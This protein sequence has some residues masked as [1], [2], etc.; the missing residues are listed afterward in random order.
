[1]F[2][3]FMP[4]FCVLTM[5]ILESVVSYVADEG[6]RV[7]GASHEKFVCEVVDKLAD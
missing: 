6:V 4:V 3:A 1:V 2:G 7:H 5:Q